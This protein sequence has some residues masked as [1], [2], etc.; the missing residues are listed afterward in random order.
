MATHSAV[1]NA[2]R[3]SSTSRSHATFSARLGG[4]IRAEAAA[5]WGGGRAAP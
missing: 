3:G 2:S 5:A 1:S 4:G